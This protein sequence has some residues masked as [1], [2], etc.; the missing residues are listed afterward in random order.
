MFKLSAS[1]LLSIFFTVASFSCFGTEADKKSSSSSSKLNTSTDVSSSSTKPAAKIAETTQT[2]GHSGD[3]SIKTN[4]NNNI[5]GVKEKNL[6]ASHLFFEENKKKAGV[7]TLPSGLQ[8][9]VLKEG[10]GQSPGPSDFVAV[11]Y[12]GTLLNGQEFDSSHKS[13]QPAAFAVN[14]VIPGWTEA[15]QLMKP[16][17][18]WMIYVPPQLGYGENGV[19]AIGPNSALIF[20]VD[21]ISVKP[22]LDDV[23]DGVVEDWEGLD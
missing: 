3:V 4:N 17:A 2:P 19:G 13:K 15:L 6:K 8:Y 11:H 1:L 5:T 7:I 22:A 23:K 16:G 14:G 21:L 9:H 20:E 10:A 12:R 18:K